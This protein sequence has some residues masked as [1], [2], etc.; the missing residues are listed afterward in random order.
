MKNSKY[1][2]PPLKWTGGKQR[3]LTTLLPHIS[4]PGRLIEPFVGAGAVFMAAGERDILIND[5]NSSLIEFY[6][7]LKEDVKGFLE[8]AERLFSESNRNAEAYAKNRDRFNNGATGVERAALFLYLNK[9]GFNGL[10]RVNK[11]GAF[12]VPYGHPATLP[13]FPR[14]QLLDMS[15]KLQKV[16]ILQGEFIVAMALAAPGDVVYCDPPYLDTAT[17]KSSFTA[18]TAAAFGPQQHR[19]LVEAAH[20]AVARGATVVISNHDNEVTR[21]LYKGAE[22]HSFDVRR[23]VAANGE[24]RTA[25]RELIAV[26][27]PS[28]VSR[29]TA[30]QSIPAKD[31]VEANIPGSNSNSNA[32]ASTEYF[33]IFELSEVLGISV[34]KLRALGREEGWRLPP[35][36][37]FG[38]NIGIVRWRAHEVSQW[39][40]ETGFSANGGH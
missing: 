15:A 38:S 4:G 18:Y 5:A 3:I 14:Q 35:P 9:F 21:A 22:I 12:N 8:A 7:C 19:E 11:R 39:M 40:V 30:G 10:Y 17:T 31:A 23:S 27:R 6:L 1:P 2:R 29:S 37:N 24:A 13:G 28:A 26:F 36:A 32:A 20:A 33:D 34:A 25:A 16:Q